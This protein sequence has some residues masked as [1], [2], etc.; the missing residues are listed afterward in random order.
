VTNSTDSLSCSFAGGCILE[1]EAEGLSGMLKNDSIANKITV[2]EETCE[3]QESNS[4]SNTTRCKLPQMST[5]YS[6]AQFNIET[7]SEDLK[8]RTFFGNINNVELAFDG[9]LVE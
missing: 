2:C 5:V 9:K 8:P 4:T 7:E 3:Y 6:N 1:L